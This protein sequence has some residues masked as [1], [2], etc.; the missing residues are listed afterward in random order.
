MTNPRRSRKRLL[1]LLP[2]L[3]AICACAP[4]ASA[5]E[6]PVR[7][8]IRSPELYSAPA[9]RAELRIAS[10]NVAH[11]RGDSLNQLLVSRQAI[12]DNLR[13]I[14]RFLVQQRIDIVALQEADAPSHWSG[15]FHHTDFLANRVG[16][17]WWT[18]DSH[19]RLGI[20]NYGTA[21]LSAL[22]ITA[23][24]GL[25]FAP[26]P[27]TAR[28]GFTVAEIQWPVA[29]G[30]EQTVDVISVHMDFSRR[31][32]R[33]RQS[34]ELAEIMQGRKN[35]LII[36]GDFNSEALASRLVAAAATNDRLLHTPDTDAGELST[37][38]NKR[39]DWIIISGE[40][41]FIDY[42]SA[43]EMLSDH[44]A[45]VASVRLRSTETKD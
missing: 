25:S 32:V 10:L 11:G 41:E 45:V 35:P 31:S 37:Y 22:P 7:L 8:D 44:R 20:A 12:R 30:H 1:G 5:P 3:L 17:P 14:A 34:A 19:A 33:E 39:L 28:K 2:M 21:V 43:P 40:L 38:K 36:M 18:Q 4:S 29:P 42:R 13:K 16:Y 6:Q 24:A 27:P 15:G 23:A 9:A 26:S